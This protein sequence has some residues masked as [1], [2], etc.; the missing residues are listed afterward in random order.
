MDVRPTLAELVLEEIE[1]DA[2]PLE[3]TCFAPTAAPV[4]A[5]IPDLEPTS[6]DAVVAALTAALP[7]GSAEAFGSWI[8][9][10]CQ[11]AVDVDV[12]ALDVERFA[13]PARAGSGRC[14]SA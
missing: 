7:V 3:P 2:I 4:T 10:T 6:I 12:E 11:M 5:L 9:P 8:E 13:R 1:P 14:T